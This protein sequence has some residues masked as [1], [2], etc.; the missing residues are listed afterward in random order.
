MRALFDPV[1]TE[2]TRLVEQQVKAA[3][4]TQNAK[5]NVC[6]SS[7]LLKSPKKCC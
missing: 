2:I 6:I 5:I 3:K 4:D 1:I 7:T